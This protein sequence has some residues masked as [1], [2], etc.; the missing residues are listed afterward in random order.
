MGRETGT[1]RRMTPLIVS[2][3]LAGVSATA[4]LA[5]GPPGG[6]GFNFGAFQKFRDQH[7]LTFQLG[8]MV[9]RGIQDIERSDTTKLKPA[10]A[11]QILALLTPLKKQPN[12]TE[13]QAKGHIQKLQHIFDTRQQTTIDQ[14][15]QRGQRR[16][17]GFGGGGGGGRPGGGFGGPPGGGPPGGGR[18]GGGFGGPPGGGRPGGGFAAFDPSKIKNVN[19]F[20]PDKASPMY[21]MQA[22]RNAKLFTFLAARAAGKTATLDLPQ[23]FGRGGGMRGG[24]G[25]PGGGPGGRPGG[26]GGPGG[27]PGGGPPR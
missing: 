16:G 8:T 6:G 13:E 15:I 27:R 11:K 7:K 22:D 24:M 4:V 3:V 5:Q 1:T 12:I 9:T 23:G 17:G 19:P 18:P 14:T 25:G 10:Q 21:Q 2:A 26:F 20:N